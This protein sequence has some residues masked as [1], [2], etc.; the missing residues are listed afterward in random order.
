MDGGSEFRLPPDFSTSPQGLNTQ[1]LNVKPKFISLALQEQ[2][3][4]N[5]TTKSVFSPRTALGLS[6]LSELKV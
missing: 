3:Q 6:D 4:K 2:N 5:S 1:H